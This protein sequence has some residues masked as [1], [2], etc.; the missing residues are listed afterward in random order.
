LLATRFSRAMA[1]FHPSS[2]FHALFELGPVG[3]GRRLKWA[4][5]MKTQCMVMKLQRLPQL[6]L[7]SLQIASLQI[8]PVLLEETGF[9]HY[10]GY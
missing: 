9:R 2:L 6:R 3:D 1:C 4:M 8:A 5:G 10:T 7:E